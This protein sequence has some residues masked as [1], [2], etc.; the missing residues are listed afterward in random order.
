M[1]RP[2]LMGRRNG[3]CWSAVLSCV[4][5]SGRA[6]RYAA[7]YWCEMREKGKRAWTSW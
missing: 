2:S 4:S 5:G 3:R 6:G 7:C 1:T